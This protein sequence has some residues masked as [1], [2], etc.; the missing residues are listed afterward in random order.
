MHKNLHTHIHIYPD[1]LLLRQFFRLTLFPS[2]APLHSV[3]LTQHKRL[4][5][6]WMGQCLAEKTVAFNAILIRSYNVYVSIIFT[7]QQEALCNF[8]S[9]LKW[10]CDFCQRLW[11]EKTFFKNKIKCREIY[12]HEHSH[13]FS[14][15]GLFPSE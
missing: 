12:L 10:F 2:C 8:A 15:K 4:K 13:I 11:A 1:M 9:I 3:L 14:C 5:R 7:Q 6:V